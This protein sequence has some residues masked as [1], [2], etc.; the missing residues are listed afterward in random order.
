[1]PTR[2]TFTGR[3]AVLVVGLGLLIGGLAAPAAAA[4]GDTGARKP[5][6]TSPVTWN[7]WRGVGLGT[8]LAAAHAKLGGVLHRTATTGGCGDLL[9]TRTGR[10]DGNIYRRPHRVGNI[11]VTRKVHYPLGLR[12][13][14]RPARAV[15][16]VKQSKY[17]LHTFAFHDEGSTTHEAWAV[18]PHGHTLYFRY[19]SGRIYRMGLAITTRVARGQ[20]EINGC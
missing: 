8:P 12:I 6:A 11:S 10:L 7:G 14:M 18:G 9:S 15:R 5:R 20:M 2:S 17:R 13:S 1:M 16:M 3:L 4:A 19:T